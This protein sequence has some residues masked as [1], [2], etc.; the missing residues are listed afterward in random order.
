VERRRNLDMMSASR[1]HTKIHTRCAMRN[2]AG[3]PHV[4]QSINCGSVL[5]GDVENPQ[6]GV[7]DWLIGAQPQAIASADVTAGSG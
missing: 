4:D 1:P 7:G 3:K 2:G 5:P 6:E